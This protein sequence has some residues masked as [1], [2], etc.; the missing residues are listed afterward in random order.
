L[1][2][3]LANLGTC[4]TGKVNAVVT[5]IKYY[6]KV[7]EDVTWDWLIKFLDLASVL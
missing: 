7:S 4:I 1:I 3:K 2:L 5:R 6:V